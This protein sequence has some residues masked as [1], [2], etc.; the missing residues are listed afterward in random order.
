MSYLITWIDKE[1]IERSSPVFID[2]DQQDN[3]IF[4][5]KQ[6]RGRLKRILSVEPINLTKG[7]KEN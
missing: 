6:R 7:V 2:G 4:F 1:D 5:K 3:I